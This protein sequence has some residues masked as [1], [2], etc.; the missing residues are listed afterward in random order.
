MRKGSFYHFILLIFAFLSLTRSFGQTDIFSNR[1]PGSL[2]TCGASDTVSVTIYTVNAFSNVSLEADLT[3]NFEFVSILPNPNVTI[4]DTSDRT[5]P[6]FTFSSIAAGGIDTVYFLI[7]SNCAST[8][9]PL[10]FSL[11]DASNQ[12]L[13]SSV[14]SAQINATQPNILLTGVSNTNFSNQSGINLTQV[15]LRQKYRRT[16]RVDY[17]AVAGQIDSIEVVVEKPYHDIFWISAGS[18]TLTPSGDSIIYKFKV[19]DFGGQPLSPSNSVFLFSDSVELNIC[20]PGSLSI[21]SDVYASWGCEGR[22]CQVSQ[23]TT[24]GTIAISNP[25][26]SY[27]TTSSSLDNY[28]QTTHSYSFTVRNTQTTTGTLAD[29]A[30]DLVIQLPMVRNNSTMYNPASFPNTFTYD[31][32]KING[33]IVP[34]SAGAFGLYPIVDSLTA[35]DYNSGGLTDENGDGFINDLKSDSSITVE[36]FYRNA[37]PN[38][39]CTSSPGP[40]RIIYYYSHKA[41]YVDYNNMC[42]LPMSQFRRQ[43][44]YQ[45][46]DFDARSISSSTSASN[47]TPFSI[48]FNEWAQFA[49]FDWT[50]V[51]L[52]KRFIVP[53]GV[54][55]A[56]PVNLIWNGVTNNGAVNES[57]VTSFGS[58]HDTISVFTDR[59]RGSNNSEDN[60]TLDFVNDCSANLDTCSELIIEVSSFVHIDSGNIADPCYTAPIGCGT[61]TI[62]KDC[63]SKHKG[64]NII[65]QEM[66]RATFGWTDNSMTTKVDEN[67]PGVLLSKV[68]P[69]DSIRLHAKI[70]IQDTAFD[71][72]YFDINYQHVASTIDPIAYL[73]SGNSVRITDV[74]SGAIHSFSNFTVTKS[75]QSTTEKTLRLNLSSLRDS[76]RIA[77]GN[78]LFKFGGDAGSSIF[79]NDTIEIVFYMYGNQ[80][81]DYNINAQLLA[82][83]NVANKPS[84]P[85]CIYRGVEIEIDHESERISRRSD[86][87]GWRSCGGV[88]YWDIGF[89]YLD[90]GSTS[91]PEFPIATKFDPV[92]FKPYT[93]FDSVYI[94]WDENVYFFDTTETYYSTRY[95]YGGINIAST[96]N[97]QVMPKKFVRIISSNEVMVY[98]DSLAKRYAFGARDHLQAALPFRNAC[99][100]DIESNSIS[101]PN[102]NQ[103]FTYR[104]YRNLYPQAIGGPKPSNSFSSFA[105]V[106]ANTATLPELQLTLNTPS[107]NASSDTV[108]W[109]IDIRNTNLTEMTPYTWIDIQSPSGNITPVALTDGVRSYPLL[110]YANGFWAKIDTILPNSSKILTIS[111]TFTACNI[112]SLMIE[113]GYSCSQYPIDPAQG[114]PNTNTIC[115]NVVKSGKLILIPKNPLIQ[116]LIIIQQDSAVQLCDTLSYTLFAQNSGEAAVRNFRQQL[117]LPVSTVNIVPGSSE[118]EWPANSGFWI[119]TPDPI[120][121]GGIYEWNFS[122]NFIGGQLPPASALLDSNKFQLRFKLNTGCPFTSGDQ[123]VF[124]VAAEELCGDPILSARNAS[125]PII[126]QG[127]PAAPATVLTIEFEEDTINIC[128]NES[129]GSLLLINAVGGN[130]SGQERLIFEIDDT[131]LTIQ[132][133]IYDIVNPQHLISLAP[134]DTVINNKRVLEWAL[135]PGVPPGDTISFSFT[136]ISLDYTQSTCSQIPIKISTAEKHEILC[137]S[138]NTLCDINFPITTTFDTLTV[139]KG[140]LEI[141]NPIVLQ[142]NCIDSVTLEF[143]LKN[144]GAKIP[145]NTAKISFASDTNN[146]GIL[147]ANDAYFIGQEIFIPDSLNLGD[148]ITISHSLALNVDACNIFIIIDSSNCDCGINDTLVPINFVSSIDSITLCS[149]NSDSLPVCT[150]SKFKTQR[151]YSWTGLSANAQLSYL[152]SNTAHKPVFTAPSVTTTTTYRYLLE[153]RRGSC[154]STTTFDVIVHPNPIAFAATDSLICPATSFAIIPDSLEAGVSYSVWNTLTLGTNLGTTPYITTVTKDTTY[155]IQAENNLTGCILSPRTAINLFEDSIKPIIVCADTSIYLNTVGIANLDTSFFV[156]SISDNC[157]VDSVYLSVNSFSCADTG[158]N[159]VTIYATD[160]NGNI[161]SCFATVIVIDTIKPTV[162]CKDTTVYLDA[163]GSFT[164][165]TSFISTSVSDICGIDS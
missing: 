151:T 116:N 164:I 72:L 32:V 120:L 81:R 69:Y 157:Q 3:A 7:K 102:G 62:I 30:F 42:G 109:S 44:Y 1:V 47:G 14:I 144:N 68:H 38:V 35:A 45:Y 67:T 150:D 79:S 18:S 8:T 77:T 63:D 159:S 29:D 6:S 160:V 114:Y 22:Q 131:N 16:F 158:S 19:A 34:F 53:K 49:R 110:P 2:V 12:P 66:R 145:E 50:K 125:N 26:I 98:T 121:S 73:T 113:T 94:S 106:S 13:G 5:L 54:T 23:I 127:L 55:V 149:S 122:S 83:D 78:P 129:I 91:N 15:V 57:I 133:P 82:F 115:N 112:D 92:E 101:H 84:I 126:I 96:T 48:T 70:A 56:S 139:V 39:T 97:T 146:N 95:Y 90:A 117:I 148:S 111:A 104:L 163:T 165:D 60:F 25:T 46:L 105:S 137:N 27:V 21:D 140:D 20:P 107:V 108:D 154:S 76:M 74:S 136:I 156:S 9:A 142:N 89:S 128:S 24:L 59:M 161:D 143:I 10:S 155:Y 52:E 4:R 58:T 130:T 31:S 37:G 88:F 135:Q 85:T 162:I 87:Y 100:R 33:Q 36:V 65:S 99:G 132:N 153:I 75:T 61:L 103:R 80:Y 41:I 11:F 147:D 28:C 118:L 138:T 93:E 119:S 152:S 43:N 86:N 51:R 124:R 64:Y 141:I 71:D 123:L 17:T 40:R 134:F